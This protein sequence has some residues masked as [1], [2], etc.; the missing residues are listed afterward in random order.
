MTWLYMAANETGSL[1]F[2]KDDDDDVTAN[3]SC[4]MK[5]EVHTALPSAANQIKL[6]FTAQMDNNPKNTIKAPQELQKKWKVFKN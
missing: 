2:D 6:C 3:R 1:M 4:R 5:S